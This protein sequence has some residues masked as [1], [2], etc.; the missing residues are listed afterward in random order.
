MTAQQRA[1]MAEII[2]NE[3][4]RRETQG[5]PQRSKFSQARTVGAKSK[6]NPLGAAKEPVD[7][8]K[9]IYADTDAKVRELRVKKLEEQLNAA[10]GQKQSAVK[11]NLE[12]TPALLRRQFTLPRLKQVY[13]LYALLLV[14]GLK[15]MFATGIVNAA[16]SKENT[17]LNLVETKSTSKVIDLPANTIPVEVSNDQELMKLLDA[18]RAE[19]AEREDVIAKKERE[20]RAQESALTEKMADLKG[21]TAKITAYRVEKDQKHE[22]R[23]E[24]LAEVYGSMAPNQAAPLIAKL[25]DTTALSLLQR[26][27]GKRMGQILSEMPSE[28]AIELTKSLTDRN[29]I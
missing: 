25:D 19:L 26:M 24:Q 4:K 18:R 7:P 3:I 8:V 20:L 27:T 1:D 16:V 17:Q 15:I 23:L 6:G 22:T 14:G 10:R 29:K 5:A 21:L 28:R 11:K 2:D 12:L 9:Q 13:L